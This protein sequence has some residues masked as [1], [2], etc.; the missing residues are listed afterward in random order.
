MPTLTPGG[1]NGA[2]GVATPTPDASA[3]GRACENCGGAYEPYREFQRFCSARCRSEHWGKDHPRVSATKPYRS[4]IV[5]PISGMAPC[6]LGDA[7]TASLS[8]LV[9]WRDGKPGT[10]STCADHLSTILRRAGA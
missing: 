10:Y 6:D 2:R 8:V 5:N 7:C 4:V 1:G 3:D 9:V